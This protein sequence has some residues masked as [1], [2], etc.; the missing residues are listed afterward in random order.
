[1]SKI[2]QKEGSGAMVNTEKAGSR[3]NLIVIALLLILIGIGI[4]II[5]ILLQEDRVEIIDQRPALGGRGVVVMPDNI[6]QIVEGLSKPV[7]DGHFAARMNVE[8]HFDTWSTPSINANVENSVDNKR[9]VYFD[10]TL[11]ETGELIYSSPFIPVGARLERFALDREV[12]AG[13]H[14]ATVTYHLVNDEYENITSVSV[15]VLLKI[16]R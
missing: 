11:D 8:W 3:K 9:T 10:L 5:V 15:A 4:A 1:M 14:P 13:E 6:E 16:S 7:P 2:K 12:P